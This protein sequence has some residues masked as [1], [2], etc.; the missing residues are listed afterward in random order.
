MKNVI[1]IGMPAVGKTTIGKRIAS[2]LNML[3][4]DT[5]D[6]IRNACMTTLPELL[7]KYGLD[8][9]KTIEERVICACNYTNTVIA[10]GGS[11]VYGAK[12]MAHLK[13]N[14][15]V[16]Y[17]KISYEEIVKRLRK[18]KSRGVAIK[19]GQTLSELYEERKILYE[20]YADIIV[21]V[22]GNSVEQTLKNCLAK[23]KELV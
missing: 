9:F 12:A 10:T 13:E 23:I 8:G 18:M 19:D 7:D 5:D 15:V 2:Q 4:I 1:L 21:G 11:A 3:F 22:D 16:V 20:K 14:G 17:L 6:V